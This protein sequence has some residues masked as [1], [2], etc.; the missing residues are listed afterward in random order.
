M[1]IIVLGENNLYQGIHPACLAFT[2]GLSPGTWDYR[3][4][5]ALGAHLSDLRHIPLPLRA[6]YLIWELEQA[7]F[8]SW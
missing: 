7:K 8:L 6:C 5:A 2:P 4:Q 3:W 1:S